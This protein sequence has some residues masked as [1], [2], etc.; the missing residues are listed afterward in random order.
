MDNNFFRR[1]S[2]TLILHPAQ[3]YLTSRIENNFRAAERVGDR[4][5]VVTAL[6]FMKCR[7]RACRGWFARNG[8]GRKFL[9]TII[10]PSSRLYRAIIESLK[11]EPLMGYR[12]RRRCRRRRRRRDD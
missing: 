6:K 11:P 1:S 7:F 4:A 12:R 9:A 10:S 2:A 8:C 5:T 3:R